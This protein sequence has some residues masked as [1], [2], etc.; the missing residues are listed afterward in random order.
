MARVGLTGFR[1]GR[2]TRYQAHGNCAKPEIGLRGRLNSR[3]AVTRDYSSEPH[4][5]RNKFMDILIYTHV[6]PPMV[7]GIETITMELAQRLSGSVHSAQGDP[8]QVT[9]VTPRQ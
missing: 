2:E 3:I 6:F 1:A 4:H 5:D 8:V 9:L 7:G